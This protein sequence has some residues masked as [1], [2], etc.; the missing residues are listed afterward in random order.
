MMNPF[1]AL[2]AYHLKQ[3]VALVEN[4]RRD[5]RLRY[6]KGSPTHKAIRAAKLVVTRTEQM[7]KPKEAVDDPR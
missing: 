3:M 5:G 1:E 2:L 7:P 4:E 6:D